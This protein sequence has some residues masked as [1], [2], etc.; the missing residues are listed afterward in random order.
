MYTSLLG[1][2]L[3]LQ[4]ANPHKRFKAHV[5]QECSI[6][7]FW[8]DL[9]KR[10]I[11]SVKQ[12]DDLSPHILSTCQNFAGEWTE[13]LQH[14]F[15]STVLI[16]PCYS[17]RKTPCIPHIQYERGSNIFLQ[18]QEA[19]IISPWNVCMVVYVL[20]LC[21][22]FQ[23]RRPFNRERFLPHRSPVALPQVSLSSFSSAIIWLRTV[24]WALADR[25]GMTV[26]I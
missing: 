1:P 17:V 15:F 25:L 7:H 21:L 24:T 19:C 20:T 3:R 23:Q 4:A 5:G 6:V 22:F 13:A 18:T 12:H 9:L 8:R 26:S 11:W 16:L 2:P 14:K 10:R